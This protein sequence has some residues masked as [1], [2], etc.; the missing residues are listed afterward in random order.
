MTAVASRGA[1]RG[2]DDFQD[3]VV[4][5][6]C[7]L[8]LHEFAWFVEAS[9]MPDRSGGVVEAPTVSRGENRTSSTM[10]LGSRGTTTVGIWG[11]AFARV[12]VEMALAFLG[13]G[14]ALVG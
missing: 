13:G 2:V 10:G 4:F 6:N 3:S 5:T 7:V 12:A 1:V 11:T 8:E 9:V 14:S